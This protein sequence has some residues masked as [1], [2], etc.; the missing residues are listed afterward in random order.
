MCNLLGYKVSN[1]SIDKL[2][3]HIDLKK[4][5]TNIISGNPQ[6]LYNGMK[7]KNLFKSFNEKNSIIIPDGI[8]V[9][10]PLKFRG[11]NIER[12]AGID[13]FTQL[14]K[15][16]SINEKT[17]YFLGS[18]DDVLSKMINI[19]KKENNNINIVG[20]HNGF[21]DIND[22]KELLDD[23]NKKNPHALFVAMGSPKQEIFI[24]K[25][26]NELPCEIF[27]GVGGT[28][29]VLSGTKERAPQYVIDMNLEWLYRIVKEPY[30]L[31]QFWK[32]INFVLLAFIESIKYKYRNNALLEN[33]NN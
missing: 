17:I 27:M 13:L 31:N 29:D 25:Y 1:L 19:L 18:S 8:G 14:I 2:L 28:F 23:I 10:A 24:E 7:N 32:N 21:I 6:V 12:I 26:M 5:K 9:V 3:E 30:R 4:E 15:H 20:T 22:C 11:E 33:I 16:L